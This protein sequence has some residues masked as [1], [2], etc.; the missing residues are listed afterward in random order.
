MDSKMGHY[1]R[2]TSTIEADHKKIIE[3]ATNVT[4]GC[5]SNEEKAVELF[6]FVRD[7]I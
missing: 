5:A 4:R 3:T 2:A 6:Y 1:L 7:S